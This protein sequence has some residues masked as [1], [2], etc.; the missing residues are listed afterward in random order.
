MAS[1]HDADEN[2]I[3]PKIT[4]NSSSNRIILKLNHFFS[5]KFDKGVSLNHQLAAHPD[6]HAPGITEGLLNVIGLDPWSSNL[7]KDVAV[8][9]WEAAEAENSFDY[10]KVA[11]E[12]RNKWEAKNPQIMKAV[13]SSSGTAKPSS[14]P[15]KRI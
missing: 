3:G 12:Q 6:F 5:L 8:P 14:M 9:F 10:T 11:I 2:F 7:P 1:Q 13:P 4:Q 15:R